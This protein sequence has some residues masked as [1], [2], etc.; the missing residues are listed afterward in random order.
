MEAVR[1]HPVAGTPSEPGQSVTNWLVKWLECGAGRVCEY[2]R[3]RRYHETE[4]VY[5]NCRW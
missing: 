2:F 5:W 1:S 3:K 4:M